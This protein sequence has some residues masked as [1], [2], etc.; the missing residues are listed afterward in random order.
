MATQVIDIVAR[1]KTRRTMSGIEKSLGKIAG[2]AAAAFGVSQLTQFANSVQTITNRLKLVTSS[3]AE[4]NKTFVDL[5]NV[6]N[7]SRQDLDAVSDLYQ[8]I[9]LSTKDLGLNQAQVS[10]TT[11]TFSKLLSI[12]G[13]ESGTAAGAIRQF[14]Q[15]LGSGAFRGDEF[16]SVVEAAP[17]IL[18]ILAAETGKA[19]GEIR[20]MA[21][22]GKLT[23][24]VLINALLKASKDVDA[25]FAKTGPTIGQSFAVLKNNFIALGTVA[26][27]VFNA[28]SQGILILANNLETAAVFGG[29][30][31][32]T[33]AVG[34]VIAMTRAV[35]GLTIGIKA[36]TIAMMKNPLGLLA[37]GIATAITAAYN[38]MKPLLDIEATLSSKII[39]AIEQAING[40]LNFFQG[41]GRAAKEFGALLVAAINPFDDID[42]EDVYA[43]FGKRLKAAYQSG[44]DEDPIKL[45]SDDERAN[46]EKQLEERRK[47]IEEGAKTDTSATM[48]IS[49]GLPAGEIEKQAKAILSIEKSLL[50]ERE[51]ILREYN[52]DKK[53]LMEADEKSFENSEF[54]KAELLAR[55]EKNK[56][57]LLADLKLKEQEADT[58]LR[59]TQIANALK[60]VDEVTRL[61]Y[62]K[63]EAIKEVGLLTEEALKEAGIDR[64]T[65]IRNIEKQFEAERMDALKK[66]E[67]MAKA[68]A[69]SETIEKLK[70]QGRTQKEA[71]NYYDFENK[72]QQEKTT[73]AIGQAKSLFSSLAQQNKKFAAIS[74]AIAIAEAIRNTYLGATK[75]LASYPPP[76]NFLA[77]AAVVASGFAQVASIR[78]QPY[79]RGGNPKVGEPALV[80]E[81]GPEIFVPRQPGTV[82]PNEVATAIDNMGGS[83][84]GPV[85]VNFNITTTDARGF[86]SLLVERRSTI[87]GI[88]NQAMNSRGK[89]GVTV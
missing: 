4:L 57:Q 40:F 53:A 34:K 74:K 23:A 38:L 29:A 85:N 1:D 30:F 44:F 25:Q 56:S 81:A 73:F 19:R 17:Q 67:E 35:G 76:F 42:V 33:M 59:E 72:S 36:L 7:R 55:L 70:Q 15:A 54:S 87:V 5:T 9:A 58:R 28:L 82:I 83:N 84:N 63:N 2:L 21:A 51:K 37:V 18:D 49:T 52:E 16:N 77:A 71:E 8:K 48:P 65:A 41:I 45:M 68:L 24:D 86:D 80:G 61:E 22:D 75:A 39:F 10:R 88:I 62:E 60:Y 12:A 6:A 69:K 20:A 3:Q 78:A 46:I 66:Q 50:D 13:A 26:A 31:I 89:T 27:P 11:E 64:A 47:A 32:A 43:E 79:Q 14:A